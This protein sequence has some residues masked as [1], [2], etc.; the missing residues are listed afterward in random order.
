M[1]T[2]K[3][4]GT[5]LLTLALFIS[6]MA[7]PVLAEGVNAEQDGLE[8]TLSTDKEE[9]TQGEEIQVT[10]CVTNTNEETVNNVSLE[11]LPIDNY[12]LDDSNESKW[13]IGDLGAG[14]TKTK[15]VTYK[16]LVASAETDSDSNS[17][18]NS[19]SNSD[20]ESEAISEEQSSDDNDNVAI[21]GNIAEEITN[22]GDNL[23]IIEE[24]DERILS[25][26]TGDN[27]NVMLWMILF[28]VSMAGI[29]SLSIL[30][31]KKG[32]KFW[33]FM[34]GATI[35]CGAIMTTNDS[36]V[37]A[38]EGSTNGFTVQKVAYVDGNE[39]NVK[40]L[41]TY[42]ALQI[43]DATT[44]T[45]SGKICKASDHSTPVI[46]A[47]VNVYKDDQLYTTLT[48][49]ST[50]NYS[51]DLP[52]G[53][54]CIK[55]NADG[56]IEFIVYATVVENSNTYMETVFLI[57]GT[58]ENSGVA[59]GYIYNALTGSG[60]ED[61]E[62]TI[63]NNW[64]N[65]DTGSVVATVTTGADGSYSVELPLGNYTVNAAKT[66]YI[67]TSFNI[68]VQ[69][70][71]TDSQNGTMTAVI[72]GDQFRIVLTWGK[73]PCDLDSHVEGLLSDDNRF[74]V[75]YYHES[76]YDGETMVCS[77]DVD[78]TSGYGPETITLNTTTEYP[79]YYYV[80]RY[81]GTGT[82]A[83]SEAHVNV[84]QG[85]SLLYSFNVPT[86]QGNGDYWNVFAIVNGE[87]IVSN[88]ITSSP[89]RRYATSSR[90]RS[91]VYDF[92]DEVL[93][94]KE[95]YADETE[96]EIEVEIADEIEDETED[97]TEV[98]IEDE[99]SDEVEDETDDSLSVTEVSSPDDE[100]TAQDD[101]QEEEESVD[102]MSVD[103]MDTC[104]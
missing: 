54:Y 38:E 93:A 3:K 89:D 42:D 16:P 102:D 99:T 94:E 14:E 69:E 12:Q 23:V 66:G 33:S 1:K 83:T 21:T 61:V 45:L 101:I 22:Y 26:K 55:I 10:I 75:Y 39:L 7:I 24:S 88:S 31:K 17:N 36:K 92:S 41:V 27:N 4:F 76:Q 13:Q 6:V 43:A 85:D 71:T 58:E 48:A 79:Y 15:T 25:P 50:G 28:A 65:T 59:S 53:D 57:E 70:G 67:S 98:D 47:N 2:W 96:D 80:N 52:A 18:I 78:E 104:Q 84:Y 29:V 40:A 91:L 100:Y 60:I 87:L 49:N 35:V 51:V 97:E 44:G 82:L 90:M 77:L 30:G 56:Y 37:F 46:G 73:D 86:D 103:D 5:F 9:Y 81:A 63:R 68:I 19:D 62:L 95:Y 72:S 20:S 74:H 34:L 32:I 64:D 8:V 11:Y